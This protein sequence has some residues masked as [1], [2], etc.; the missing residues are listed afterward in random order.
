MPGQSLHVSDLLFQIKL[1]KD[2]VVGFESGEKYVRMKEEHRKAREADA[3]TIKR[4]GG[5]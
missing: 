4:Q 3:R 5:V 1:L 2:K